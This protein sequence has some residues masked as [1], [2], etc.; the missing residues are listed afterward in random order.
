M[1]GGGKVVLTQFSAALRIYAALT[2]GPEGRFDCARQGVSVIYNEMLG[3]FLR[4][5]A[6]YPSAH[7]LEAE[8]KR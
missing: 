1:L 5:Q 7:K 6:P 8:I 4:Y 3:I 2:A